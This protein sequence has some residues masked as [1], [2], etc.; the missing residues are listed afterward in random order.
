[1]DRDEHKYGPH[2]G[3]GHADYNYTAQYPRKRSKAP[4]IVG[5]IVLAVLAVCG[6]SFLLAGVA[7]NEA[8]KELDAIGASAAA[9]MTADPKEYTITECKPDEFGGVKVKGK[10]TN[11]DTVEH[12]YW[13]N[14]QLLD[15]NKDVIGTAL[16][17]VTG[18]KPG[19][20][21][22]GDGFGMID[23]DGAKLASC[24]VSDITRI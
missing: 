24:Q 18:L 7:V 5:G 14:I 3:P 9:G 4:W 10:I 16:V 21:Y 22:T 19:Q 2:T 12:S 13:I 23:V 11:S 17:S 8:G 1:M 20:N 6:G 15:G